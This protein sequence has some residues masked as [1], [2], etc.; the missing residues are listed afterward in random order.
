[1][2]IHFGTWAI[3]FFLTIIFFMTAH[4]ASRGDAWGYAWMFYNLLAI[5]L[6]LVS[7]LVWALVR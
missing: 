6:S 7:W 1:M 5:I 2:D 3:P 4:I